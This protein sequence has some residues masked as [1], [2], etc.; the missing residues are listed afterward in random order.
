MLIINV[1]L[2]ACAARVRS[3]YGNFEILAFFLNA[4]MLMRQ[5]GENTEFAVGFDNFYRCYLIM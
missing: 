3:A 1:R 4:H 5:F 2:G